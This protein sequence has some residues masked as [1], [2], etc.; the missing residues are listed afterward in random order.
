MLSTRGEWFARHEGVRCSTS[1]P[2]RVMDNANEEQE[3]TQNVK[4]TIVRMIVSSR[5][6]RVSALNKWLCLFPN[7]PFFITGTAVQSRHPVPSPVQT[8]ST[9]HRVV[10]VVH[11]Q[12]CHV[13]TICCGGRLRSH[14]RHII[15]DTFLIIIILVPCIHLQHTRGGSTSTGV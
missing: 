1:T 4:I 12:I 10:V 11:G 6:N 5:T 14:K 3:T 15:T 8:P 7:R 13:L 2:R 9:I